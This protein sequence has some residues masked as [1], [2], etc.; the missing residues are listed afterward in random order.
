M[1]GERDERD[2]F[3]LVV[4]DSF[5]SQAGAGLSLFDCAQGRS[6]REPKRMP[7]RETRSLTRNST[8]LDSTGR[9]RLRKEVLHR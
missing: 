6:E 3:L 8:E 2:R 5:D 1:A 4:E 9:T 7:L